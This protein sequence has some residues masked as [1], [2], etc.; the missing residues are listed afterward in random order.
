MLINITEAA[1]YLGLSVYT[2]RLLTKR[3]QIPHRYIARRYM[4]LR[5]ELDLWV[6]ENMI[7]V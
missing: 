7:S 6:Q 1:Q 2:L 5:P 4:Y 3:N